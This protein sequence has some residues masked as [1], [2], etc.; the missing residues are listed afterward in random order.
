MGRGPKILVL[1]QVITSKWSIS[2]WL[3][4]LAEQLQLLFKFQHGS[5]ESELYTISIWSWPLTTASLDFQILIP[6]NLLCSVLDENIIT[7][8]ETRFFYRS[9]LIPKRTPTWRTCIRGPPLRGGPR[10]EVPNGM[11]WP[12]MWTQRSARICAAR[13]GLSGFRL[14]VEGFL[15]SRCD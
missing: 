3:D 12:A 1:F 10:L 2:Q 13:Q 7:C 4:S 15:T 9:T 8:S 14:E 5:N 11:F 6:Q